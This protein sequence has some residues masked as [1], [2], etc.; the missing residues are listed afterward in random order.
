MRQLLAF[1]L[2][3]VLLCQPVLALEQ[4]DER[5]TPAIEDDWT[6]EAWDEDVPE[7]P[8]S[9]QASETGIDGWVSDS[10]EEEGNLP[11][12]GISLLDEVAEAFS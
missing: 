5:E 8:I 11:Y 12:D 1:F 10:A 2:S 4:W 3:F 7:V 6:Q 9:T